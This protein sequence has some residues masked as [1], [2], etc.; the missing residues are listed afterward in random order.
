M[1]KAVFILYVIAAVQAAGT[2]L[3]FAIAYKIMDRSF[4]KAGE[5]MGEMLI[6]VCDQRYVKK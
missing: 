1:K 6:K 3:S 4:Y 2:V 5:S